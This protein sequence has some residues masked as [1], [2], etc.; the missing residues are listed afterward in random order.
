VNPLVVRPFETDDLPGV[1]ELYRTVF[2]DEPLERFRLRWKWE[3]FDNP[4]TTELPSR[5]R[6]ADQDGEIVGFVAA[7]PVRQ[8]VFD[9]ELV[10]RR[11]CD[12][13]VSPAVRAQDPTIALRLLLTMKNCPGDGMWVG[14]GYSPE[15]RALRQGLGHRSLDAIPFYLRPLDVPSILR[16]LGGS[17]GARGRWGSPP[18]GWVMSGAATLAN[19]AVMLWNAIRSP[20]ATPDRVVTAAL[21]AG[22]EFDEI[23][24]AAAPSVP[25]IAVRDRT[26]VKWRF[27]DDPV[28]DNTVLVA[29]SPDGAPQGYLAMRLASRGGVRIGRILDIFCAPDAEAT[30]EAL[31]REALERFRRDR[32]A[33]VSC[34]GLHPAIRRAVRRYLYVAPSNRQNPASIFWKGDPALRDAISDPANWHLSHADGD[35]GFSP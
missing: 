32:V 29:R 33:A 17:N 30:I 22:E 27:F 28:F 11:S 8:K 19:P 20:R 31:V 6:V 14:M 24:Q 15:H 18:V 1:F 7:F 2:G 5:L 26:F 16:F 34:M 9:Q 25:I 4:N 12:L 35:E 13:M 21:E 23:W 10:V 3:F